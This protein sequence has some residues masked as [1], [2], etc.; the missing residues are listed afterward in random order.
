MPKWKKILRKICRKT[1]RFFRTLCRK[2]GPALRRL[3]QRAG[4]WLRRFL[5]T[6]Y[7]L[8][9]PTCIFCGCVALFAVTALVLL[10]TVP[11]AREAQA[12]AND[13]PAAADGMEPALSGA[14]A[15]PAAASAD[16]SAYT[17]PDGTAAAEPAVQ[18]PGP[19]PQPT[20]EPTPTIQYEKGD[21][22]PA[23]AELQERLMD[24]GYMA[25][26]EPTEYFG[27][28]TKTAVELFQ[29]QHELQQDGIVGNQTYDLLMFGDAK[30]YVM[31]EG[32]EGKDIE[33]FQRSLYE[34]GYLSRNKITGYYGTDTVAAVQAF[35]KRNSLAQDGKAGEMTIA[36]INSDKARPSAEREKEIEEEK[37]KA[38]EEAAKKSVAARIETF[39]DV[40]SDQ[41]GKPYILGESG[42]D[43]YDCSGLVYYCLRK[44]SVYTRRLNASGFSQVSSWEKITSINKLKRGDL[45][46]FKSDSSDRVSHVGIY[47]GSNTMIDASASEGEVVK[48]SL[49]SWSRR[50]FVCGRRP[51]S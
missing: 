27:P 12:A 49:G 48:R 13:V 10:I 16:P 47:L 24:L 8:G 30:P 7:R 43:S 35:Q 26:D 18:T 51:I 11:R 36:A 29:R 31:Y 5:R 34:L 50:N 46:F 6:C 40:A 15:A 38:E 41:L 23:I 9:A 21:E 3:S 42:P 4:Q 44:A 20:P 39:I 2:A 28:A 19:T 33:S 17:A 32:A 22:D 1:V 45:I 14:T 37:K 25:A